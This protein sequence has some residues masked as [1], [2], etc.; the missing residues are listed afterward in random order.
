MDGID[1]IGLQPCGANLSAQ[2]ISSVEIY[3]KF[4]LLECYTTLFSESAWVI[5][6]GS[7]GQAPGC[8][9]IQKHFARTHLD[10]WFFILD[11]LAL[12]INCPFYLGIP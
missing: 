11:D 4:K 5:S 12:K 1:Y 9:Y 2:N 3:A 8:L 6:M 7:P 10:C